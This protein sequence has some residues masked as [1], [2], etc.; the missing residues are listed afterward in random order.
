[1]TDLGKFPGAVPAVWSSGS[2]P[3]APSGATFLVGARWGDWDGALAVTALR[4]Q[5]LR[6]LRFSW[7]RASVQSDQTAITDRG[8]L[9]SPVQGPDGNLYLVTDIGGGGGS[10][11]RVVPG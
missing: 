9:R 7:S 1:M 10:I 4:G 11:L 3:I 6:V 2:P 5:Q 8:R